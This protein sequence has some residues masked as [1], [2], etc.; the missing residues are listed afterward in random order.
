ME[1]LKDL[2]QYEQL[3]KGQAVFMYTAGWCPDCFVIEPM[4]PE[5]VETYNQYT[6]IKINRD[7]FIDLCRDNDIFGIPSFVVYK[8]G[9]ELGRFVSKL[10]K[11]K[12]EIMEFMD[13]L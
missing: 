13:S 8:E 1:F 11:S 6:W 7:D 12:K 4:L 5:L 10:R 9:Q 3:K 2:Q